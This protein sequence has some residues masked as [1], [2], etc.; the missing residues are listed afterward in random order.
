MMVKMEDLP[1]PT[2]VPRMYLPMA[3]YTSR[4]AG[5]WGEGAGAAS[6]VGTSTRHRAAARLASS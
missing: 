6:E 2:P 5:N 4:S 1:M 3:A